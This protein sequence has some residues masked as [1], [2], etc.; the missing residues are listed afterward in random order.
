MV[1]LCD[2]RNAHGE[3]IKHGVHLERNKYPAIAPLTYW[4]GEAQEEQETIKDNG[5]LHMPR[6]IGGNWNQV[7]VVPDRRSV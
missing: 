3:D 6:R 1:Q 5:K 7:R 2:A 4:F